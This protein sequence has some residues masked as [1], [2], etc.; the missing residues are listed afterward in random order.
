MLDVFGPLCRL[1]GAR[2]KLREIDGELDD[3]IQYT[4]FSVSPVE[5]I[6]R[7]MEFRA[8]MSNRAY[9]S[10][11]APSMQSAEEYMRS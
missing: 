6:L 7:T 2:L 11:S 1:G 10:Q 3:E 9:D 8:V 4:L 5:T